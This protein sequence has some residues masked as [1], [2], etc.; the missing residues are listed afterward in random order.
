MLTQG[1][2]G[3]PA[4]CQYAHKLAFLVGDSIHKEPD[5]ALTDRLYFL[6]AQECKERLGV[7]SLK[8]F[9]MNLTTLAI[10]I[11]YY[12]ADIAAYWYIIDQVLSLFD[13]VC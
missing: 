5:N 8:T 12:G 13:L 11:N 3:V 7:G 1:T 6:W 9:V 10:V 4:P 2:V